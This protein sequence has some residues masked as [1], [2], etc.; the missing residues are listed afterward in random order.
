MRGSGLA[1][2]G[3][4]F[5]DFGICEVAHQLRN[6]LTVSTD[7]LRVT[8]PNTRL[9]LCFDFPLRNFKRDGFRE[10]LFHLRAKVP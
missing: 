1:I 10:G 5:W 3:L 4:G 2:V 6:P 9:A 7:L 8:A